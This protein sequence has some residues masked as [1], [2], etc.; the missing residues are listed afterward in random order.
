M[1]F[2][3]KGQQKYLFFG[4]QAE[5]GFQNTSVHTSTLHSN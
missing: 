1:V 2:S 3:F 4:E 5:V